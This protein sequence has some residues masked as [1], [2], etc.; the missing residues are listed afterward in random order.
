ME[1]YVKYVHELA[2]TMGMDSSKIITDVDLSLNSSDG[3]KTK[4]ISDVILDRLNNTV[5]Q[6]K[7]EK[8]KRTEKVIFLC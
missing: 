2:A 1:E 5:E 7:E 6:L 3:E 8:H 4:N